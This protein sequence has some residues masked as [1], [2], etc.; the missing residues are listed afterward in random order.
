VAL[1]QRRGFQGATAEES[2]L[3][4]V[5][6]LFQG[7]AEFVARDDSGRRTPVRPDTTELYLRDEDDYSP[8]EIEGKASMA[9][10]LLREFGNRSIRHHHGR[11]S[12]QRAITGMLMEL[13]EDLTIAGPDGMRK[14]KEVRTQIEA[15]TDA[16]LLRD[17]KL[18]LGK[19]LDQVRREGRP[20]FRHEVARAGARRN[21]HRRSVPANG[22]EL[23]R[24]AADRPAFALQPAVRPGSRRWGLALLCDPVA[25]DLR[26]PR[27]VP[28]DRSGAGDASAGHPGE[29]AIRIAPQPGFAGE[30]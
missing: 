29:G 7:I 11:F 25:E 17:A 16:E 14:L 13:L 8:P 28:V 20:G 19:C 2:F 1:T 6:T 10:Q 18:E 3:P 30:V 15:A 24:G 26:A 23:R 22:T 21:G 5:R 27:P 12:E 9:V 4:A